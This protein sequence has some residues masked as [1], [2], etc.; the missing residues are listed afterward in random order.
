M[1]T[2][3]CSNEVLRGVKFFL[4]NLGLWPPSLMMDESAKITW[5]CMFSLYFNLGQALAKFET[6]VKVINNS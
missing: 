2:I 3:I 1:I 5:L 6:C 4:K